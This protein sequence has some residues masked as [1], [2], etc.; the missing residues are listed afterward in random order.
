M[1]TFLKQYGARRS[2][3]NA[4]RALL[5]LNCPDVTVLMHVLGDKHSPPASELVAVTAGEKTGTLTLNQILT[6]TFD[7]PAMTTNPGLFEQVEYITLHAEQIAAAIRER[8]FGYLI[9]VRN[10]YIWAAR[11]LRFLRWPISEKLTPTQLAAS[12]AM[13]GRACRE[14]NRCYESWFALQTD[15]TRVITVRHEDLAQNPGL[16]INVIAERFGSR[17]HET[18]RALPGRLQPT[19]WDN[20]PIFSA[21]ETA[22]FSIV[23]RPDKL[24]KEQCAIVTDTID[25][26]ILASF[27][28]IPLESVAYNK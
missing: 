10:P 3:T 20:T 25:W 11:L 23:G 24:T 22:D 27:G 18:F 13:L 1:K 16:V 12:C 14:Y 9:S 7:N 5:T 2:G 21:V 28:Y 26:S 8:R 6:A 15:N 17:K 19:W 4:L